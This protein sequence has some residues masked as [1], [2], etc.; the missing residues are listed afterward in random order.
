ARMDRR[1]WVWCL[2]FKGNQQRELLVGLV[3]PEFGGSNFSTFVDEGNVLVI[4]HVGNDSTSLQSQNTD[5]GICFEAIVFFVLV[6]HCGGYVLGCLIQASIAFLGP[7]RLAVLC[8]LLHFG[9]EP[10]IGRSD[11]TRNATGHLRREM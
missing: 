8:V 9:P 2:D 7:S 11:L 3:V 10:L 1:I 4:S 6:R 5:A